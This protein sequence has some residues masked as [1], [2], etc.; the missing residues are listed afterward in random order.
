MHTP[1]TPEIQINVSFPETWPIVLPIVGSFL[2]LSTIVTCCLWRYVKK[3]KRKIN[4]GFQANNNCD[5]TTEKD[6]KHTKINMRRN[7]VHPRDEYGNV[8]EL[9]NQLHPLGVFTRKGK[10]LPFARVS[11]TFLPERKETIKS[12]KSHNDIFNIYK[13]SVNDPHIHRTGRRVSNEV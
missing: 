1:K 8:N 7:A 10:P 11:P 13:S 2:I 12:I 6:Y 9:K 4:N 5:K 3:Q